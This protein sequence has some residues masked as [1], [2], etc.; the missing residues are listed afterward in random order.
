MDVLCSTWK[1]L[2][3]HKSS[4]IFVVRTLKKKYTDCSCD[5]TSDIMLDKM[6]ASNQLS[7]TSRDDV[8]DVLL[9]RHTH[10]FE[11]QK[12]TAHRD[13]SQA[14]GFLNTV[15]SFADIGRNFSHARNLQHQESQLG[16]L[17]SGDF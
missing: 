8:K 10:Q 9:K 13:N 7:E 15:R 12:G 6:I 2:T 4:V 14:S 3:F 16:T 11:Y 5:F 17:E 1:P